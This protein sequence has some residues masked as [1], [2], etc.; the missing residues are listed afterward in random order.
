ME[1]EKK[2]FASELRQSRV[3]HMLN[4]DP[5]LIYKLLELL[6]FKLQSFTKYLR[7]T[8]VFM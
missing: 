6:T 8:L 1:I 2:Q 5:P 3:S 7:Q 4:G